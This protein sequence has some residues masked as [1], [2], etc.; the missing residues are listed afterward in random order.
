[1]LKQREK[2]LKRRAA[3]KILDGGQKNSIEHLF[4]VLIRR[5]KPGLKIVL[6]ALQV[7]NLN[8]CGSSDAKKQSSVKSVKI[9]RLPLH[10]APL[11]ECEDSF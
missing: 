9:N 10:L 11:N 8:W 3:A 1:M 7:M 2:P 5:L 4:L 6:H